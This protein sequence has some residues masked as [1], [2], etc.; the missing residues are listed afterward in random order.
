ME[1]TKKQ[2]DAE[3]LF[4]IKTR[5]NKDLDKYV[6][7]TLFPEKVARCMELLK[8]VKLPK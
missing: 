2:A 8:S 3:K 4:R 6:G 7:K 5:V 1:R